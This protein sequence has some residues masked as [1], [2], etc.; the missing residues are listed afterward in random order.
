MV[1]LCVFSRGGEG[2]FPPPLELLNLWLFTLRI[3]PTSVD[4]RYVGVN[5]LMCAPLSNDKS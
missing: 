4:N 3:M 5:T 1:L 2:R